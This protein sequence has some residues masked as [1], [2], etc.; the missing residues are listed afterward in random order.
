[1]EDSINY[2]FMIHRRSPD[3]VIKTWK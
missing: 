1:M 2:Q 3:T